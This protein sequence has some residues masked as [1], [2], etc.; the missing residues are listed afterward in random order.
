MSVNIYKLMCCESDKVY[1]GSTIQTLEKRLKQHKT[2]GNNLA[3][4]HLINPTIELIEVCDKSNRYERENH[5]INT[6]GTVYQMKAGDMRAIYALKKRGYK[7]YV[8]G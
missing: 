8:K 6:V 4:K 1:V 3:S 7:C 5:W 2:K